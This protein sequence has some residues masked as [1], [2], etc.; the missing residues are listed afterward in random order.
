MSDAGEFELEPSYVLPD[1]DTHPATIAARLF[2]L[3][4]HRH[5]KE[6]EEHLS[7]A[8]L[9]KLG[10]VRKG[11]KTVLGA[12]HEPSVQG[13]LKDLFEQMLF[14]WL[15]YFPR[16]IVVIDREWWA[17]A[18]PLQREALVFHELAHIKQDVD[19]Y[20]ALKFDRDGNPVFRLVEHD[21][22]EFNS[23]VARYGA[24]SPDIADFIAAAR[25]HN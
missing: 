15:G 9:M 12:V 21:L 11:G 17:Q 13:R 7:L 14:N 8:W 2:E 22:A 10:E 18:T 23:V 6:Y 20:G 3:D 24:W 1:N 16:F 19:Q 4:E 5:F 25:Q